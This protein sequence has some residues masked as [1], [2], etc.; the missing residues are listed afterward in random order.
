M[1]YRIFIMGVTAW[2]VSH[3]DRERKR[4]VSKGNVCFCWTQNLF[5]SGKWS[6][7]CARWKES[8]IHF[9]KK[10]ACSTARINIW[11]Q[12]GS[13]FM[14]THSESVS[15]DVKMELPRS[16]EPHDLN[17]VWSAV[18]TFVVNNKHF[19][20]KNC[21]KRLQGAKILSHLFLKINV[22]VHKGRISSKDKSSILAKARWSLVCPGGSFK[23]FVLSK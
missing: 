21:D 1:H 6:E 9:C 11:T 8:R 18:V 10:S 2:D 19:K 14:E 7:L 23:L 22:H 20:K 3:E 17:K 4:G 5:K 15:A 12:K 16:C 13:L